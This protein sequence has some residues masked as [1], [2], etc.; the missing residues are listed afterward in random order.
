MTKKGRKIIHKDSKHQFLGHYPR[1]PPTHYFRNIS[2]SIVLSTHSLIST[3]PLLYEKRG[4]LGNSSLDLLLD[5]KEIGLFT[6]L[7]DNLAC[8]LGWASICRC[9]RSGGCNRC[10]LRFLWLRCAALILRLRCAARV[11]WLRCAA[12]VLWTTV[13]RGL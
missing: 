11:S 1:N 9:R 12:R 8:R 2:K 4:S 5:V 6:G 7:V 3:S 10:A 13:A